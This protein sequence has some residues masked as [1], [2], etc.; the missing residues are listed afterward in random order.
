MNSDLRCHESS[1]EKSEKITESGKSRFKPLNN[2]IKYNNHR[3][4]E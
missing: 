1:S 4:I 2:A 3:I